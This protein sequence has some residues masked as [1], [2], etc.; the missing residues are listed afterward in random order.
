MSPQWAKHYQR[1]WENRVADTTLPVW[2]RLA[3][4]AYGRHEANGHAT[5]RR[6]QLSWILG[7][8]PTSGQPFKRLDKYTVRDAIKLAV[9]HGWLADG[10]CSECLIVPAHAIEGPQGN[11]AKPCA[12]HERKIASKRKSRL[13]LA[14]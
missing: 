13:R 1:E 9:S 12:V 5:F 2:L 14:S 11:P 10:S 6:G 7:T 8:P 4:L 3:C